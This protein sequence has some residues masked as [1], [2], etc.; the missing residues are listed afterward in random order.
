M[1]PVHPGDTPPEDPEQPDSSTPSWC[2]AL[3]GT[4]GR[5]RGLPDLSF[6]LWKTV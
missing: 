5:P 1:T 3:R 2:C 4:V 6:L